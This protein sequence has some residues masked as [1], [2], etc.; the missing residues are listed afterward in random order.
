MKIAGAIFGFIILAVIFVVWIRA[1]KSIKGEDNPLFSGGKRKPGEEK[2]S[3]E[4]FIASYKRGEVRIPASV[5]AAAKTASAPVPLPAAA[6]AAVAPAAPV[7]RESFISGATKLAYLTCKAGLRDHHVFAHV[8]LSALSTG[9]MIDPALARS[10]VDLLICNAA[11]S[12][13]AAIDLIDAG[14]SAANVAKSDHLKTLGIRYLRLSAKSL[15][16]PDQW[17]AL[18]YKM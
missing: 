8:Q 11:M 18:L 9:G 5:P 6:A 17:H 15:P 16:R 2:D 14:S 4:D 10:G 12:A 3:L 13:V 7:R 1:Y